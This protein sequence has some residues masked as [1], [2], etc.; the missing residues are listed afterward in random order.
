[1]L[2]VVIH[3]LGDSTMTIYTEDRRPQTGWG[4]KVAMFFNASVE[5][6]NWALGGRSSRSFYYEAT[7]W[8]AIE[9]Q[10]AAGDYVIIQF[11][12]NDQKL[13][14][15]YDAYGTYAFCSDGTEDG[16]NCADSEHSYYQFLKK[17]VQAV[18]AK[19]ATPILMSPIVRSYFSGDTITAKGQ[20]NL[21]AAYTGETYARGDYPKAMEA[22]ATAYEV[23]YVDLTAETKTIVE[24]Y[25]AD[26]AK[27]SLYIAADS[28]HP[29]TLF[30]TLIA[31]KAV[32]G[33]KSLNILSSYMVEATSLVASPSSLDWG[34]RYIDIA[35]TKELTI[36]A[37]DLNPTTGSVTVTAPEGFSLA[38]TSDEPVKSSSVAIDYQNGAFT[39]KLYVEFKAAAE[40][41]YSNNISFVQAADLSTLGFVAVSGVGVA[42]GSGV[43]SFAKWFTEGSAVSAISD[44][45][46]STVDASA[47]NLASSTNKT[48]AVDG[49]DTS[50][51]RFT[52]EGPDMVARSNERYLQFAV[53]A[54]AQTFYIDTISVYL[55]SSGGSTVQADIEY[56]T[57]SDFSSSVKLNPE[58]MAF[59][60]DTMTLKEF[61]VTEALAAGSTL[62]IR[63]YPW[64]TA[65]NL[66]KTLAIYGLTISGLSGE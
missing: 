64:N 34:N 18:R 7:R 26:A 20:H 49:Q 48:L 56:S 45:L 42:S 39:Q 5:V 19:G 36:S 13:G 37:F 57:A 14:G 30:A 12:H 62:Y 52:V 43:E 61:G 24:S 4:E 31:K 23:P 58:A 60:K 32:E 10:I 28:T 15:D 63:I 59:T 3:M 11:G 46:V 54:A 44:G 22:V 9:P 16:E 38:M 6:K 41:A 55:T 50:V 2:P 25:G 17:Y 29:Q 33:M 8:P 21:E 51:A 66:G 53:T 47:V 1:M 40:Q 35:S 27:D 65:G